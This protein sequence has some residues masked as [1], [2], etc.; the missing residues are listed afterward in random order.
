MNALID[1]HGV[2]LTGVFK[3][4]PRAATLSSDFM[5]LRNALARCFRLCLR[6]AGQ[7]N[8]KNRPMTTLCHG[9]AHADGSMMLLHHTESDPQSK[10]GSSFTF[11]GEERFKEM[12]TAV[13]RDSWTVISH[14]DSDAFASATSP[15]TA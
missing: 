6:S 2:I 5:D 9:A 1:C 14:G 4:L 13:G 3:H 7:E 11:R 15:I 8:G 12:P 10:S